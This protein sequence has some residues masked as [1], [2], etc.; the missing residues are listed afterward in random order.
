[1]EI[2]LRSA[3]P[4]NRPAL[5]ALLTASKLPAEDLPGDL[6]GF[7]LAFDGE[8]LVGSAGIEPVGPF[9][10]LRSVAVDESYRDQRLGQQLYAA[11][12]DYARRRQIREVWLITDTADRYFEKQGFQRI[13]RDQAPAEIASTAQFAGLCP[14]SAVV[15]R[16]LVQP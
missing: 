4:E 5:R 3:R 11:A 14:S 10:L 1:M 16:K 2:T 12:L 13:A 7:T 15:M 9:G 8:T 6:G